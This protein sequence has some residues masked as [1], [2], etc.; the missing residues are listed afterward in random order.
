MRKIVPAQLENG[1]VTYGMYASD[2]GYGLTGAFE[3]LGPNQR[4][5]HIISS[6]ENDA[7]EHVSVSLHNRTP[8]WREMCFVKDLFWDDEEEVIQFHPRKSEYVNLH[9]HCL[10][11]WRPVNTELPMPP[12][13]LVG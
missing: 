1:R 6:G 12:R 7:W 9:T 8:N 2:A 11:L 13:E 3:V 10:H 5:L 4:L